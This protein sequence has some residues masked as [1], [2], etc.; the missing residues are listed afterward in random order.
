MTSSQNVC[1]PRRH[2]NAGVGNRGPRLAGLSRA[3]SFVRPN[4]IANHAQRSRRANSPCTP[5]AALP[6]NVRLTYIVMDKVPEQRIHIACCL[7]RLH[8]L[9]NALPAEDSLRG[10]NEPVESLLADLF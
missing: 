6:I 5:C 2:L 9:A 8:Q 4:V 3:P 1:N 10:I 7:S